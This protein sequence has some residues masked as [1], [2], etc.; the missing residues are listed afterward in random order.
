MNLNVDVRIESLLGRLSATPGSVETLLTRAIT[1]IAIAVQGVVK[2][3][4]LSGQVLHNRT[5]TLRRSI[6]QRVEQRGDRIE[7]TVGTNVIYAG[8]HE[9]GFNGQVSV[10]G[11][12]RNV[13]QAAL[14]G[15]SEGG[16]VPG[17]GVVY[18]Q[19]HSRMLRMP[20]RSYLRSTLRE[21]RP[22]IVADIRAAA[23]AG[24]R[25]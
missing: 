21:M 15:S 7:G 17:D 6:N 23:L 5:G 3:R 12:T 10:A 11:H 22:E 8:V 16:G 9:F 14:K 4:K 1:R 24:L 2:S 25:S 20:E 18:V 13:R 19:S